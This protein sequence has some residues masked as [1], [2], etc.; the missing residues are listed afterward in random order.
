MSEFTAKLIVA[1]SLFNAV[2]GTGVSFY[3]VA[4]QDIG[5]FLW[6][7]LYLA[8]LICAGV[9]GWVYG[10]LKSGEYR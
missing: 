7:G 8:E 2:V 1:G 4:T 10:G 6:F 3:L 9:A 5:V